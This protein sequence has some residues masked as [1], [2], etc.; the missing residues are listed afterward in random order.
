MNE[1][2]DFDIEKMTIGCGCCDVRDKDDD[3][4]L[5]EII[6]NVII[7]YIPAIITILL[8]LLT[9]YSGIALLID[10]RKL[11]LMAFW[12][13]APMMLIVWLS[14]TVITIIGLK[15]IP[16]ESEPEPEPEPETKS[17][18]ESESKCKKKKKKSPIPAYVFAII[19][20]AIGIYTGAI[21]VIYYYIT[22]I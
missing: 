15:F 19:V 2:I 17:E 10:V 9:I 20:G 13:Y 12:H 6:M 7:L 5:F 4:T 22:S 21:G 14:G 11:T 8:A 16:V 3:M 1:D 18:S